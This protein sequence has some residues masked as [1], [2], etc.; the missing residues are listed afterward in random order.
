MGDRAFAARVMIQCWRGDARE[1]VWARF[2]V[3]QT[4]TP[5]GHNIGRLAYGCRTRMI[6]L[7]QPAVVGAPSWS[8]GLE[9][10]S[11][12]CALS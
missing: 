9:F 8:N 12:L 3:I 4:R 7:L 11:C 1:A 10:Q 2:V 6:V 5:P